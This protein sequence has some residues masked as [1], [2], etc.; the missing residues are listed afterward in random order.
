MSESLEERA[1]GPATVLFGAGGGK[2]PD[3]N[4]LLVRG[5]EES[6][7]VDP[8]LG[9]LA[10]GEARPPV[11]RVIHSHC[12]EDHVAGSHLY[13]EVPWHFHEADLPG[14]RSLQDMLAIY[15]YP[16]PLLS[17]FGQLIVE[18]FHFM[19]RQDA[20]GFLDGDVFELGGDVRVRVIHTPGHTRGHCALWVEPVDLLFIGDIDLS[21][22]GPYYADAWSD[23]EDFERSLGKLRGLEAKCWVTSHHV[24]AIDDRATFLER[25]ERYEAVIADREA[26]LLDYL[27]EPHSMDEIVQHRFVLRPKD[28][29]EIADVVERGS[30]GRHITRL[31]RDGRIVEDEPGRYRAVPG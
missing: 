22:F 13:A 3:A 28:Q 7:I 23:L 18:R 24:G 26:R 5:P 27:R 29:V 31:M 1:F 25:F 16:E 4:S 6:L 21:S 19:P 15:G 17:A 14:I 12:H 8:S 30:M 9:V 20:L 2:Y 11:D 10:R